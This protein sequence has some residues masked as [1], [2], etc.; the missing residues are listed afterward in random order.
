MKIQIGKKKQD[1][2][3]Q[4]RHC[5]YGIVLGENNTIGIIEVE[6]G[7][8]LIGGGIEQEETKEQALKR[9]VM[10]EAGCNI[11]TM[12]SFLE[13]LAYYKDDEK[14]D[15][16]VKASCFEIQLTEKIREPVEKDH[17]LIWVNPKEYVDRMYRNYQGEIIQYWINNSKK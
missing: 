16:E 1:M 4:T 7:Y 10:E 9:E 15:L 2:N 3:Y 5:S 11:K 8:F 6:G 12:E 17:S 13:V 14:G